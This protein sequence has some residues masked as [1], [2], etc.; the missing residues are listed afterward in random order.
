[1]LQTTK[2]S[3]EVEPTTLATCLIHTFNL[4]FQL[5]FR[6]VDHNGVLWCITL[7]RAWFTSLCQFIQQPIDWVSTRYNRLS[8]QS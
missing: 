2:F 1:M 8:K 6:D 3:L 7:S 4:Y 5:S